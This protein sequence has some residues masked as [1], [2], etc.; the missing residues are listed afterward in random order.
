MK[1]QRLGAIVFVAM[2]L[3]VGCELEK[4][5]PS[6]PPP[7]PQPPADEIGSAAANP[8][9]DRLVFA[10]GRDEP[11]LELYTSFSDGSGR[12]RLTRNIEGESG[13]VYYPP[14]PG[15]VYYTC[16]RSQSIC[17]T[18]TSATGTAGV[19]SSQRIGFPI[20]EDPAISPD[21][22]RMLLTGVH[23]SPDGQSTNY[24]IYLYDFATEEFTNF[25][26]GPALDQMPSWVSNDRVVWSRFR[27]GD[28]D[29][30]T[31]QLGAPPGSAPQPLTDN[32]LD[33]LGVDVSPDGSKLAWIGTDT[34]NHNA[35][36]LFTMP[37]SP[38]GGQTPTPLTSVTLERGFIGGDPDVAWSPD[39]TRIAFVQYL[40]AKE[41]TEIFTIPATGGSPTNTTNND[42]YD[43]D[44]DWANP[45]P[46]VAVGTPVVYTE[47]Q[48]GSILFTVRLDAPQS[49]Q[50]TVD[51]ATVFGTATAADF[52]PASGTLTFAPG[53]TS[54]TVSVTVANDTILEPAE[55]F[56]LRLS[57][58]SGSTV[59]AV[60]EARGVI[61]DDEVEPTPT[62]TATPTPTVS[63]SPTGPSGSSR[64]AFISEANGFNQLFTM[65]PNGTGVEHVS[66][67]QAS[68]TLGDPSWSTDGTKIIHTALNGAQSEIVIRPATPG[69]AFDLPVL[70]PSEDVDP[71]F[72]GGS[73]TD[74]WWGS[75]EHGDF[76]LFRGPGRNHITTSTAQETAPSFGTDPLKMVYT[77][78]YDAAGDFDIFLQ[79]LTAAG[80]LSGTP[81][82]L[83]QE[84][85]GAAASVD[86]DPDMSADGT[87]VVF[88][89]TRTGGGDIYVVD[90]ASKTVTR[91]TT[92]PAPEYEPTFSPNGQ[93][94]A[95]VRGADPDSEI[96]VMNATAG[97]T[98][99]NIS[100]NP[101]VDRS[102]DWG[103]VSTS[104]P[105]PEE[106]PDIA[107]A[108]P[109]L[110]AS[111]V[112]FRKVRE[113]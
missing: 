30:V 91:L 6:T 29:L 85:A 47:G 102:P 70:H 73:T 74:F 63:P 71:A 77:A 1:R 21:G 79:A 59:I 110:L 10:S 54:K 112:I 20:L 81:E 53:E 43:I 3:M 46:S 92:D 97:A 58:A 108:L 101:G 50:V 55:N 94:I 11:D 106:S 96:F 61:L 44:P 5:T 100:N 86:V 67:N 13:A 17:V 113:R 26:K 62:R 36:Q 109:F 105:R 8:S 98:A 78:D 88:S 14:A 83:T 99:T 56:T 2:F 82:N 103:P 22:T 42:V 34:T 23:I 19:L 60:E 16:G 65:F 37:F 84:A 107:M 75:N 38:S 57:N 39:G 9:Q 15:L 25:A 18:T 80:Q 28:W 41:N 33:D 93:Q 31:F 48:P 68:S 51:F 87:K 49:Q 90:V 111:W 66:T 64:I 72:K 35:G 32:N 12:K 89:S 27:N 52:T 24:D 69:G 7:A 95:F 40:A 4:D 45:P 104:L 76:D